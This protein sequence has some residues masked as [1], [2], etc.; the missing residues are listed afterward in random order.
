M[1]EIS[2]FSPFPRLNF[3]PNFTFSPSNLN[4]LLIFKGSYSDRSSFNSTFPRSSS[5]VKGIMFAEMMVGFP[6]LVRMYF[7]DISLP[8][9]MNTS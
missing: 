8:G 1:R 7:K 6:L 3:S 9:F 5:G 4:H 2:F